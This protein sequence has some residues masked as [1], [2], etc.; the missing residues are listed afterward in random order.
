MPSIRHLFC[1]QDAFR[2]P[3]SLPRPAQTSYLLLFTVAFNCNSKSLGYTNYY[4]PDRGGWARPWGG[5]KPVVW[6]PGNSARQTH[7][8]SRSL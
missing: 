5:R 3:P 6:A 4:F 2:P 8:S 7:R 1:P